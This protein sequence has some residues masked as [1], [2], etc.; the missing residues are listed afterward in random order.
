M[1]DWT[2]DEL[3]SIGRAEELDL[4]SQRDNG[5]LRSFVTMWVARFGDDLYVRAAYGP[6]SAWFRRALASGTGR[7][8]AGGLERDVSFDHIAETADHA[9]I[10]AAYHEKYDR[11]GPKI[12]NT[13]VGETAKTVTIRL[14]PRS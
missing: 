10:D 13:V 1:D 5:S 14:V 3:D 6:T 12:V 4:A 7:I 9:A 8:R 11:Y 2:T